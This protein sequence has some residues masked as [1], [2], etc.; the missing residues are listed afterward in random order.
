MKHPHAEFIKAF[1]EGVPVQF[2]YINLAPNWTPVTS[3][4]TFLEGCLEF[5][6]APQPRVP[7]EFRKHWRY[8]FAASAMQAHC[9]TPNA[10]KVQPHV[11]AECA[12]EM[13]D[14]LLAELETT[15]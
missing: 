10:D 15:E 8:V 5:R 6:L 7:E 14:A 1:A 2:R 13:A 9:S 3:L 12:R 11:I 4:G